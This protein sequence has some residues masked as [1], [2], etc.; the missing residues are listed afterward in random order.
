L[1]GITNADALK[2]G[3][4]VGQDFP[5]TTTWYPGKPCDLYLDSWDSL[6]RKPGTRSRDNPWVWVYGLEALDAKTE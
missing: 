5:P 3:V 2:E 1:Q 6:H 4:L